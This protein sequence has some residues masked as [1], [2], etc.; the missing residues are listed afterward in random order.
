[1]KTLTLPELFGRWRKHIVP[2]LT[3]RPETAPE[4]EERKA[5]QYAANQEW[6]DEGGAVKK[7]PVAPGPRTM[8]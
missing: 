4:A 8:L 5:E 3:G 7:P 1:M 2:L 6:E